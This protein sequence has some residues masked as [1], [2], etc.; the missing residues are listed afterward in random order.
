LY[1]DCKPGGNRHV[2]YDYEY[3]LDLSAYVDF[4]LSSRCDRCGTIKTEG[5]DPIGDLVIRRYVYPEG[6]HDDIED[7]PTPNQIRLMRFKKRNVAKR[8]IAKKA[9]KKKSNVTPIRRAK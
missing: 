3:E 9:T 8:R 6:Y 4:W 7:R 2:W 1:E 5:F